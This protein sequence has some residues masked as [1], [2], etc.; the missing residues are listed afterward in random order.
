MHDPTA[1]DNSW[2]EAVQIFLRR[3]GA[4]EVWVDFS[5]IPKSFHKDPLIWYSEAMEMADMVVVLAPMAGSTTLLEQRSTI[6]HHT[7]ELAL[8]LVAT[9][10][11]K[12]LKLKE[13]NVLQHFVVLETEHCIVPD[14]CSSFVRFRAPDQLP[15]FV[16]YLSRTG[17]DKNQNCAG[18]A[19]CFL[20]R[21]NS[22]N[23]SAMVESFRAIYENL[24]RRSHSSDAGSED[25]VTVEYPSRTAEH[26]SLLDK[27]DKVH[28]QRRQQL[29]REFGPAI[30]SVSALPTL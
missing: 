10:I 9:R 19:E 7:F 16:R 21:C 24:Q 8:E 3:L 28:D 4:F 14:L 23:D 11:S 15:K 29:D 13:R 20:T 17:R 6:Y 5:E 22:Y 26:F 12:R 2:V 27:E 30:V 1:N 18:V 25:V